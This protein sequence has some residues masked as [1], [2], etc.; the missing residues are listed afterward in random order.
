MA[1]VLV[2]LSLLLGVVAALST[3]ATAKDTPTYPGGTSQQTW[4]E[5]RFTLRAPETFE[6]GKSYSLMLVVSGTGGATPEFDVLPP[7]DY[8]VCTPRAT[9]PRAWATSEAK[10]RTAGRA[11][12]A[13]K[14]SRES[15]A[16]TFASLGCTTTPAV[17]VVEASFEPRALFE[18][19][20]K[21]KALA[22]ALAAAAK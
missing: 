10:V 22:K 6:D 15:H 17:V 3:A 5:R 9:N 20:I 14:L 4:D 2:F 16:E 21:T 19:E 13:I 7:Q 12:R 11:L 8:V 1:R 18:G